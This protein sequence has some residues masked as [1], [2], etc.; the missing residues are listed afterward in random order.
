[1]TLKSGFY[2]VALFVLLGCGESSRH[3]ERGE[4]DRK[5]DFSIMEATAYGY[6]A[7]PHNGRIQIVEKAKGSE[8]DLIAIPIKGT[9]AQRVWIIARTSLDTEVMIFPENAKVALTGAEL[10]EIK[11]QVRISK[12]VEGYLRERLVN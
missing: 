5:Y 12:G 3:A 10:L 11:K 8:L 6:D 4:L 7:V 2:I 9:V 1:M